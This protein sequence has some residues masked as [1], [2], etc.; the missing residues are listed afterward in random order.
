MH[1]RRIIRFIEEDLSKIV[2]LAGPRQCGKTTL[3]KKLVEKYSGH[4]YSWDDTEDMKRISKSELDFGSSF[5]AFD[6]LHKYRQWRNWLKGKFD[7]YS[8]EKK[9]LVTGSAK[10]DVYSRGGDSMQGRYFL[11]H[12]HPFTYSELLNLKIPDDP[13]QIP[14]MEIRTS[15]RECVS[16]L[17]K[18]SGF[19]EPFF[20]ASERQSKRWRNL[21]SKRLIKEDLRDLENILQIDKMEILY[22]HLPNTVS[23]PLSINSLREDLNVSFETVSRWIGILENL[24]ACFR[25]S[26]LGGKQILKN[27][28][29]VKKEQK[30]YFWDWALVEDE[31]KRFENMLAMHLLRF[32]HWLEDIYG[33]KN[34]LRYFR[35]SRG[36]EVDFILLKEGKPWIAIEA[37][38]SEQELDPNLKY[39]LDRVHIPYAFQVHLHGTKHRQLETINGSKIFLIPADRFLSKLP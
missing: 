36:H 12:L 16:T 11:H 7:K 22:S 1:Q 38:L 19:P 4:F 34:E 6:E 21:Y 24:Y 13:E 8:K 39:L 32:S 26:P 30:L 23:S 31:A 28:R 2:L 33:I 5:W 37:K 17:L 3:A 10:L 18:F 9:I 25:L 15:D 27:I 20:S 14:E 29:A 35:D